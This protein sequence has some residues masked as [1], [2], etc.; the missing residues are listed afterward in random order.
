V[1]LT[2]FMAGGRLRTINAAAEGEIVQLAY[3]RKPGNQRI[4]FGVCWMDA[5]GNGA[6]DVANAGVLPAANGIQ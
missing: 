5:V 6:K 2:I 1:V 3:G 4:R